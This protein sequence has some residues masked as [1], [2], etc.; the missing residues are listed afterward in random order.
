IRGLG[1]LVAG[2]SGL[3][4]S[5][6]NRPLLSSRQ[7]DTLSLASPGLMTKKKALRRAPFVVSNESLGATGFHVT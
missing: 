3:L 5:V 1:R 7:N 2:V 4:R 6:I